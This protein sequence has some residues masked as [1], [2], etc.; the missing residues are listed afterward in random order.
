MA[1][2]TV[3]YYPTFSQIVSH[4]LQKNAVPLRVS[5]ESCVCFVPTVLFEKYQ[6]HIAM[7]SQ[8]KVAE[9]LMRFSNFKM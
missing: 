1:F 4:H 2:V 9:L 3:T 6:K 8:K 7:F 5:R